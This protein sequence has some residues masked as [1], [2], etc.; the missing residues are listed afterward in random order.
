MKKKQYFCSEIPKHIMENN[1]QPTYLFDVTY[2]MSHGR[3]RYGSVEIPLSD[4]EVSAIRECMQQYNEFDKLEESHP[5]LHQR[6]YDIIRDGAPRQGARWFDGRRDLVTGCGIYS[7]KRA[8][9]TCI[10][11]RPNESWIEV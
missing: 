4:D 3:N 5:E 9:L 11:I 8:H 10:F 2:G 7:Y 1:E 6:I